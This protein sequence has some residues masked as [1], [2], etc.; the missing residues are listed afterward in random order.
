MRECKQEMLFRKTGDYFQAAS[1]AR[2]SDNRRK[3]IRPFDYI[4]LAWTRSIRGHLAR[5]NI[6][7]LRNMPVNICRPCRGRSAQGYP[8]CV[9]GV[10]RAR[11]RLCTIGFRR[12]N[13]GCRRSIRAEY[14]RSDF[15]GLPER[16]WFA[17]VMSRRWGNWL[18]ARP[19]D[20]MLV[21]LAAWSFDFTALLNTL[22]QRATRISHSKR[23]RL[24][25]FI[26]RLAAE[27]FVAWNLLGVCN[28]DVD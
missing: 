21:R 4:R 9:H 11:A 27:V 13:G 7:N 10:A 1:R 8:V 22:T 23:S 25:F 24:Y 19:P 26:F 15:D 2:T 17:T 20:R 5:A 14:A 12:Q 3:V 6:N 16:N 28:V 18:L